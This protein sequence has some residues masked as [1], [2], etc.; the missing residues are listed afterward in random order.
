MITGVS[1]LSFFY[2][3]IGLNDFLNIVILSVT[4]YII[5]MQ[6]LA[7]K[8]LA[9]YQV[10]PAIDVNMV[11]SLDEHRTY[12]WFSNES[13][14]PGI[15]YLEFKKNNEKKKE[16]YSS[17][18]IPPKRK[19]KTATTFDFSPTEGDTLILYVSIKPA[20]NKSDIGFKFEKS[21][22]FN[23]NIW[24]ESSWSYPDPEFQIFN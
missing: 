8:K 3:Y 21:Y 1:L 20:L 14:L 7:T 23:K 17:L 12:F 24:N 18:R 2:G 15:V 4:A 13:T 5:A 10:V 11:Y 22:K 16:V 19:M 9:E 6:S